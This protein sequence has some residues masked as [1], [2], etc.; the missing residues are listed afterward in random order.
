MIDNSIKDVDSLYKEIL[1]RAPDT[2]GAA[3]W[4]QTFGDTIDPTEIEIFRQA[5]EKF[6][7]QKP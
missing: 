5:A 7:K 1:G 4:A 6:R 3:H 2:G